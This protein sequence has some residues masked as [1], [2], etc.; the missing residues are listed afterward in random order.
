[1]PALLGGEDKFTDDTGATM[2]LVK[3]MYVPPCFSS[4]LVEGQFSGSIY[5]RA[6][7]E[8]KILQHHQYQVTLRLCGRKLHS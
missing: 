4:L 7:R 8:P 5:L 6:P 2:T 3:T 1:M